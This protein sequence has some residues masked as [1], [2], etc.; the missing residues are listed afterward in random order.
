MIE[1]VE[2]YYTKSGKKASLEEILEALSK[3]TKGCINNNKS[4]YDG[5]FFNIACIKNAKI[6]FNSRKVEWEDYKKKHFIL[7]TKGKMHEIV[8]K[9]VLGKDAK[10]KENL[11]EKID[12]DRNKK[13]YLFK[14]YEAPSRIV[15]TLN[16]INKYKQS[17]NDGNKEKLK[18][19][20]LLLAFKN[21]S[22]YKLITTVLNNEE[23]W[24]KFCEAAK[25]KEEYFKSNQAKKLEA[26]YN[27]LIILKKQ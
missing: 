6:F 10:G 16:L 3:Y 1:K 5:I 23:K 4:L 14:I 24:E 17:D 12:N 26:I 9:I 18:R 25:E 27:D 7:N 8:A 13:S 11:P 2:I 21:P 19:A 15:K 20:C 22:R